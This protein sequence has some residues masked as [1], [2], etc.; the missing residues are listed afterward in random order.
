MSQPTFDS[1][2]SRYKTPFGAVRAGEEF[3]LRLRLPPEPEDPKALV[4]FY[5]DGDQTPAAVFA[6]ESIGWEDGYAWY[7][8]R[9]H[10]PEAGLYFYHFEATCGGK[11]QAVCRDPQSSRSAGTAGV[12]WQLTVY[13]PRLETPAFLRR[14]VMYQIFP[15]RF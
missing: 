1:Q 6:M 8:A 11:R 5:R 2:D 12:L 14:G 9:C 15:D 10:V 4:L 7:Q 13:D 3:T